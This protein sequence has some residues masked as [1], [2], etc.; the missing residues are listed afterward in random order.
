MPV[1]NS[2]HKKQIRANFTMLFLSIAG[3]KVEHNKHNK[4]DHGH[5]H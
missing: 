5:P 3:T 2:K 4:G 1:I